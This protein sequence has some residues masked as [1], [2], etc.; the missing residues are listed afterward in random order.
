MR[1]PCQACGDTIGYV[2]EANGQEVVRCTTCDSYA[3]CR[4]RAESGKA[5]R[6]VSTRP[7]I[8]LANV[9]KVWRLRRMA[10]P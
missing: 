5:Q 10:A 6:S 7:K 9:L 8:K 2:K 4:P 1:S 3:C